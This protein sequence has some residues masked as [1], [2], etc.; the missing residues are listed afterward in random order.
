MENIRLTGFSLTMDK[1]K[2]TFFLKY[3]LTFLGNLGKV[4]NLS[5]NLAT[6]SNESPSLVNG[7]F[8]YNSIKKRNSAISLS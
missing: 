1:L 6:F 8:S 7:A 2:M 4:K 5:R 3:Q